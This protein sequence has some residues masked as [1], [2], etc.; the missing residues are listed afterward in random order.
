MKNCSEYERYDGE[1]YT[2]KV[3]TYSYFGLFREK[4]L[5]QCGT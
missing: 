4:G 5:L 3:Y 2:M 1:T